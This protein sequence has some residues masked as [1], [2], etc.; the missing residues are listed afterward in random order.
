MFPLQVFMLLVAIVLVSGWGRPGRHNWNNNNQQNQ[1]GTYICVP[2]GTCPGG[3]GGI[4]PRIVTPVRILL[5]IIIRDSKHMSIH[6]I[7]R[8]VHKAK[9]LVT[10]VVNCKINVALEE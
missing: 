3:S 2:I 4:D 5:K 10:R 8:L 6:R 9:C 7:S 1:N